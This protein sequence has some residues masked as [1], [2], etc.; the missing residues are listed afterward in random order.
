[1]QH[2]HSVQPYISMQRMPVIIAYVTL[3]K[4]GRRSAPRGSVPGPSRMV[5]SQRVSPIRVLMQYLCTQQL[6]PRARMR[7]MAMVARSS[8]VVETSVVLSWL[9][10]LTV[11]L[12]LNVGASKFCLLTFGPHRRFG[13]VLLSCALVC[14]VLA[15]APLYDGLSSG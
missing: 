5:T 3:R 11:E 1:M 7:V 6:L 8:P 13:R 9:S 4:C 10:C 15:F 2:T 12:G 14:N